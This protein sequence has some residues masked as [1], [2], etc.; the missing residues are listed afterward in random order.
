VIRK[1]NATGK[2]LS[3][4]ISAIEFVSVQSNFFFLERKSS[5]LFCKSNSESLS[6]YH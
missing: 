5:L 4:S 1:R 3:C 2:K 6:K